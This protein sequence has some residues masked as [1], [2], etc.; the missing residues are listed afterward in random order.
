MTDLPGITSTTRTLTT[1]SPRAMSLSRLE[2]WLPLMPGAGCISK[3]VM[4]GPGC[5]LTT[6]ASMRKSLSLN[7]TW[8]DSAS[9]V[10]SE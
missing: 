9:S 10:S 3:R 2:I 7:S 8:R 1:E 6:C 5:A 4:T